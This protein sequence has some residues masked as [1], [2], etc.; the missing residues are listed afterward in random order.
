MKY[1]SNSTAQAW[2]TVTDVA[3]YLQVAP[4]TIYRWLESSKIPA[5]RV[6]R[7]WRFK[8]DEVDRWIHSGE[9]ASAVDL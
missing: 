7:Q 5:H 6:G 8:Y 3:T 2:A 1:A 4:I 9:S